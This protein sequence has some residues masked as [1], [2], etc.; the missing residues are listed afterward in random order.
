MRILALFSDESTVIVDID[1]GD[2]KGVTP[3][4]LAA[5]NGGPN[6]LRVLLNK[7]A[8]VSVGATMALHLASKYADVTK[9]LVTAG[10][11]TSSRFDTPLHVAVEDGHWEV[12]RV[13]IDA[14]ADPDRSRTDG[15]TPLCLGS[16]KGH[17]A[18]VRE[19]SV[20]TRT[21]C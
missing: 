7:G 13:L 5:A 18:A 1:R 2:D 12:I 21:R 11:G 16:E 15:D 3:L 6:I 14:G 9:M 17:V 19:L 20:R 4:M 10:G 8:N